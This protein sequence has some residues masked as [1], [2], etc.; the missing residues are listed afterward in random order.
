MPV[1]KG[2]LEIASGERMAGVSSSASA[3]LQD[4]RK[5][6]HARGREPSNRL[7]AQARP[8]GAVSRQVPDRCPSNACNALSKP[9]S[10]SCAARQPT[11]RAQA[12]FGIPRVRNALPWGSR[13]SR[14]VDGTATGGARSPPRAAADIEKPPRGAAA[15]SGAARLRAG[16][17]WCDTSDI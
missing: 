3:A 11:E 15:R 1:H 8:T 9:V 12:Q 13:A 4:G 7:K 16:S 2:R 6:M 17:E 14:P 10:A 5:C